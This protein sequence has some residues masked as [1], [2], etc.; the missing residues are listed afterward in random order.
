LKFKRGQKMDQKIR[1]PFDRRSGEDR[2]R[3]YRLGYFSEGGIERR[4]GKERRSGIDRRADW[5]SV[6][7]WSGI[8][9]QIVDIK[10]FL[11]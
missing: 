10:E 8:C 9:A 3:T 7:E 4:T 11:D 6:S 2:R 5:V 1:L